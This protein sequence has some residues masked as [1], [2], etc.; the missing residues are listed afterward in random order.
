MYGSCN[1]PFR[2]LTGPIFSRK[3][4]LRGRAKL[5]KHF[6]AFIDYHQEMKL[7]DISCEALTSQ[8]SVLCL[9]N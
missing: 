8:L 4:I 5:M 1:V 3:M 6:T 2:F 9:N 7:R